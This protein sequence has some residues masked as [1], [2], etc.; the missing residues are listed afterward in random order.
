MSPWSDSGLI[1]G[2]SVTRYCISACSRVKLQGD[3]QRSVITALPALGQLSVDSL[4]RLLS[5]SSPALDESSGNLL[6]EL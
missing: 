2:P 6:Y 1:T 3:L 4:D 5:L